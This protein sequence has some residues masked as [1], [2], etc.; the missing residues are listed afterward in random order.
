MADRKPDM[1][2]KKTDKAIKQAFY[3]LLS[4][5][6]PGDITVSELSDRAQISRRTFYLRYT[7]IDML[8]NSLQEDFVH[9]LIEKIILFSLPQD[10]D[11]F[12][13][14][15]F[16]CLEEGRKSCYRLLHFSGNERL[17]QLLAEIG[18]NIRF[19]ARPVK[20][21]YVQG[22]EADEEAYLNWIKGYF[23]VFGLYELYEQ[24]K[25]TRRSDTLSELVQISRK[26]IMRGVQNYDLRKR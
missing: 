23:I 2:I 16:S 21:G 14:V 24:W 9:E 18:R 12:C 10:I 8:A 19:S 11:A 4:E 20:A 15:F 1:R 5:K 26:I 22:E 25:K 13:E 6:E 7:G 17:E 3:E